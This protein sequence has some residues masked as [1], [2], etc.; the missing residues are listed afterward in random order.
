[1]K[2]KVISV[3]LASTMVLSM[4][5]CGSSGSSSDSGASKDDG[6]ATE[7]KTDDGAAEVTE[8]SGGDNTLTV[9]TWDPNFNIFAMN[10]AA[11]IYA[12][13][14]EGFKVEISEIKSDVI[15]TK[16]TTAV[17]A[18]DLS[19]LPDIFLM[20][21]NSFQKYT[22]F[23]PDVF[24]DLTDSGID[25]SQ[26]SAAKVAYSTLEGKNYGVPFDNGAVINCMR[27]DLLE[28][29]GFTID[30]FTDITWSDYME[31]AKVVLEK[32]N[33]PILTS[34]AGS[35]DLIMMMLQSCGASLFT[36]D[37]QPNIVGNE[38]L[39]EAIEIYAQMVKDGTL[40]EVTDWD[41]YISSLNSG[42]AV[43]ALNGC[44][45]MASVQMAEDQAGKWAI[46]NMPKLDKAPNASNYSNNGGSSWAI[47]SNCQNV[48]LAVDFLKST[49][50]G[51]NELYD[52]IIV[53]GALATW[54][55]AGESEA[56]NQP[57]DFYG[58]DAVYAK[59]V[60]YATKTP[61]NATGPF[62]YD[63]RDA[64]GVALS[65]ITQT[66]ADID[67][68]LQSAQEQLEFNMGA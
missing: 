6:A 15:E 11:E 31:K 64:V 46:T 60:D 19:T 4:A 63:A 39:K 52:Q 68:S 36:D 54:A 58:G 1:M 55:P 7:E 14:H 16:I 3:L 65:E 25:F 8:G 9:W 44:W 29:A 18:N 5:A 45:I 10:K 56:Y 12:K 67:T 37:G 61:S 47:S 2:R 30:D 24:T 40:V 51:S 35:P 32:T 62:Y 28:Q 20:Q 22:T 26:F 21:D 38:A 13:D 41:P 33:T 57:V 66:G 48:D 59:I 34:Q 43:S 42:T 50:A 23:Y 27:T 49:F 53:N 17:Q